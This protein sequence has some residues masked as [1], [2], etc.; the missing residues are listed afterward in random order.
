M[1]AVSDLSKPPPLK[2]GLRVAVLEVARGRHLAMKSNEDGTKEDWPHDA[3]E[4]LKSMPEVASVDVI[5]LEP[6]ARKTV[7]RLRQ[8]KKSYDVFVNLYDLS[9]ETGAKIAQFCSANGIA[10]TGAGSPDLDIYDPPRI[11]LKLICRSVGVLSPPFE[12]VEEPESVDFSKIAAKLGGLDGNRIFVKPEHGFDSVG[13]DDNSAVTSIADL[14]KQVHAVFKEHGGAL[15]ERYI[16]G[17]EFSV[18]VFGS[19]PNFYVMPPV[20]YVFSDKKSAKFITFSDKWQSYEAHWVSLDKPED[21]ALKAQLEAQAK[22][23]YENFD[24]SDGRWLG[25]ARFDV[26]QDAA[27]GKLYFLDINPN[28][29]MFYS[30]GCT[31]DSIVAKA[32]WSKVD[33]MRSLLHHALFRSAHFELHN[34]VFV[35]WDE[36]AGSHLHA[37][38]DLAVGDLVYTLENEPLNFCTKDF[39][40]KTF[41]DKNKYFFD[42]F[43]WPLGDEI[44]ATW[45]AKPTKWRPINHSC[46]PN[47]WLHNLDVIARRPIKKGEELTLDYATFIPAPLDFQCWCGLPICRKDANGFLPKNEFTLKWFQDRYCPGENYSPHLKSLIARERE[48]DLK[49]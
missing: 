48:K 7:G 20:E 11:D 9:D 2:N 16:D 49:P 12:F 47:T 25:L 22:L 32:G 13:V 36:V 38:R 27:T 37:K 21:A 1:A 29:S 42:H 24:G 39:V 43:A 3:H 14:E 18:L 40:A 45:E 30:D 17:R 4:V 46:D 15:V 28:P 5:F 35:D 34:R 19:A 33:L 23:L 44:F 10:F 41:S 26:R 8:L 31:C 6:N